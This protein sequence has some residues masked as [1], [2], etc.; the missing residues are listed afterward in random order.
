MIPMRNRLICCLLLLL[1]TLANAQTWSLD[2]DE[3]EVG[4]KLIAHLI[5]DLDK[6]DIR[7]E[8]EPL[9][10]S[11]VQFMKVHPDV[12]IEVG[13]HL[14][15]RWPDEY[16]YRLDV[17]R[18]RSIASYLQGQGVDSERLQAKGYDNSQPLITA[19]EIAAL[20]SEREKEEAHAKNRR[21]EFKIIAIDF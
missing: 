14:D 20:G 8:N 17:A 18:A 13:Y 6:T 1:P 3:Y 7:A 21:T 16:S 4:D 11:I 9:L 15:L 2:S 5:F 19:A 12:V 10:D